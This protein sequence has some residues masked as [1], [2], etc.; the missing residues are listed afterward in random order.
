VLQEDSKVHVDAELSNPV[1]VL[2]HPFPTIPPV[3]SETS[4]Q[5]FQMRPHIPFVF[6]FD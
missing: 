6:L 2:L 1:Q 4:P 3:N 5:G